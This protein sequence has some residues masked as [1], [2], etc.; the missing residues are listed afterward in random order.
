MAIVIIAPTRDTR[1]W[2]QGL[3]ALDP[4][5]EIYEHPH[6]PEDVKDRITCAI[7][8]LHPEGSLS[9]FPNLNIICSMGAGVDHMLADAQLPKG[10][11]ITR[12][13]DPALAWSMSNFVIAALFNHHRNWEHFR[14]Q[15]AGKRWAQADLCEVPLRVGVLGLGVLGKDLAQKVSAL[16]FYT[17]GFSQTPK[18]VAGIESFVG[19]S[20]LD[21]FLQ[22]VNVLVCLLPLT[23]ATENYLNAQ[24][25]E[26]CSPG[27]YLINVAR[28]KHLVE[29]DLIPAIHSGQLSGAVLDVFREE[30][31]PVHHPFWEHPNIVITPHHASLTNPDA[32]IPQLLE[33]YR[34]SIQGE[35]LLNTV[36]RKK[37][38]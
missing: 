2:A 1:I 33:N 7:T 31:L 16:G 24:L 29:E 5:L 28:G 20:Q 11:P 17:A 10:V 34:R 15:Q 26:R 22:A 18:E 27:T 8:W 30:P 38:Y 35:Q 23:P 14:K 12:I 9:V 6:V 37:G 32:A 19:A 3:L 13:V 4:T 25:F 36:D 21:A